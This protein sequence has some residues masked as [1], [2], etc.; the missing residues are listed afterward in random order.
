MGQ[1]VSPAALTGLARRIALEMRPGPE[2]WQWMPLPGLKLC[3]TL[4]PRIWRSESEVY[5]VGLGVA[6]LVAWLG[7]Q[8]PA[9]TD[10]LELLIVAALLPI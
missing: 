1:T 7:V 8:R 4:A 5:A 3:Q 6:R 2:V 9:F 10:Q